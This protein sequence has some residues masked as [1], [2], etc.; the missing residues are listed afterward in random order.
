MI[1]AFV[2]KE[3][4]ALKSIAKA[5]RGLCLDTVLRSK[6]GHIGLPL[7]AADVLTLLYFGVM[8]HDPKRPDWPSRDRFVLSAGHGSA[9]LYVMLHLAGYAVSKED[10]KAFRQLG[11]KT[12]GHPE[13]AVTPGVECTT[14]PLGQGIAMAVG[15]ALAEAHLSERFATPDTA[16]GTEPRAGNTTRRSAFNNRT[17]ALV[18]DGCLMEGVAQEAISLAGH[19]KLNRLIALYDDNKITIDGRTDIT[20]SEDVTARFKASGWQVLEADGHDFGDLA[21]V[22]DEALAHADGARGTAACPTLIVCRT[23]AGKGLERWEGNPKVHG[24]P[25]TADDVLAAK[26]AWG[27]KDPSETFNT[28]PELHEH[29]ARLMVGR[30]RRAKEWF[31]GLSDLLASLPGDRAQE[32]CRRFPSLKSNLPF[33]GTDTEQGAFRFRDD[34]LALA[35]G[36]AATRVFS[37]RALQA[38]FSSRPELI[39]GSADLAGSN[40]TTLEGS[41]FVKPG[42]YGGHNIHF[43]VREHAMAALSNGLALY[44]GFRP[45]CATFAVFSDYMRPAIRLAALMRLPTIFILTHDSYAVGEDGPT[46]QPIEHAAALRAIPGLRVLR[47][48]D[49]LETFAAWESL[50][51]EPSGPVALLLTR[52][53]VADC[54][55]ILAEQGL[56]T[57]P[58]HEVVRAMSLGALPLRPA[59]ASWGDTAVIKG[60]HAAAH[61]ASQKTVRIC[62]LA[63]GSEVADALRTATLLEEASQHSAAPNGERVAIEARVVSVPDPKAL[64]ANPEFLNVVAPEDHA[65]VAIEAG[66]SLSF[67]PIVGRRGLVIGLDRFGESAPASVL[68]T[69]FDLS[70]HSL[71]ARILAWQGLHDTRP[72]AAT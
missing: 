72:K 2:A 25:H 24:N 40:N 47:P 38:A 50:L 65:L 19:L 70:P 66:V 36:E 3:E 31:E 37:G 49:G 8:N 42:H 4:A 17:F 54:D 61:V 26:Q 34:E 68:K 29:C 21:R 62:L 20:F 6:S 44:G 1:Q 64:A 33:S 60:S 39:G 55:G 11:S 46:H 7:G 59:L 56:T 71:C 45:F 48:A 22:M 43:G 13:W 41:S 69:H 51:G 10:L 9:L 23:I 27:F 32:L 53:N 35:R 5:A 57:R 12:P 18:G 63:S 14:G 16:Q 58:F 28:T 15:M 30:S 67:S 52:Q